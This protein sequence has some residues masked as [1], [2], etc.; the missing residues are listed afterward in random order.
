MDGT[1]FLLLDLKL[2]SHLVVSASFK[3]FGETVGSHG[4][5]LQAK[6]ETFPKLKSATTVTGLI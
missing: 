2:A 5:N 6:E 1:G 4:Q 3:G